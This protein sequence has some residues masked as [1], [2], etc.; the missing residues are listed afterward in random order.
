MTVMHG[1]YRRFDPR[2]E[3]SLA[4]EALSFRYGEGVFGPQNPELRKLDDIRKTLYE[5][6]CD[7]PDPV[8]AIAMDVGRVEHTAELKQ[9]MLL[10]GVVAYAA[11]RLGQE[12]VRSQGHVHAIAPHCGWSTPELVE[13]WEG[14]AVVY[15]QKHVADAPECCMAIEARPGDLVVIPP[16]WAHFIIN[17]DS[18]T[19]LLFGAW[20]DRQYG[21][22]YHHIRERG[23]L[24]WFPLVQPDGTI[25]WRRNHRYSQTKLI[26]REA[27][28]YRELDLDTSLPIY[29]QFAR[30]PENL[31][32]V[33]A[34]ARFADL[35]D[36]FEP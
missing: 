17:A 3:I 15:L 13:V 29:E 36:R 11:G 6:E 12:P 32:W 10:F 8:Y 7:G 2:L 14:R 22:V 28:Q 9:R 23:G 4:P 16:G 1:A 19:R 26:L 21:F 20:C 33:S 24:A 5:S 18:N 27:R 31:Q 35:W 25:E 34:P 30:D